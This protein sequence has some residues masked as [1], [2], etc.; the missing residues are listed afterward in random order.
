MK[1]HQL[2]YR[3][4]LIFIL[5]SVP[6]ML[7]GQTSDDILKSRYTSALERDLECNDSLYRV[8][9][10]TEFDYGVSLS[11]A[12]YSSMPVDSIAD[13][14]VLLEKHD[15]LSS[16][17]EEVISA[18]KAYKERL[19]VFKKAY[20]VSCTRFDSLEVAY[21][22]NA[23]DTLKTMSAEGVQTEEVEA[24]LSSLTVYS[25]QYSIV[26]DRFNITDV[27]VERR[28]KL[29]RSRPMD[30]VL[31]K[32]LSED[33]LEPWFISDQIKTL[34]TNSPIKY[35]RTVTGRMIGIL[36][37]M[38]SLDSSSPAG[39]A[40]ELLDELLSIGNEL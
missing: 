28:I 25:E 3:C 13:Y 11:T 19:C 29:Y 33:F 6:F 31:A 36:E 10:T 8:K 22:I 27:L 24:L 30:A 34:N 21:A 4:T 1:L 37:E 9:R 39:K 16:A 23:L 20:A 35:I 12:G 14:I 5:M 18:L 40:N 32:S 7:K 2:T 17:N 38:K 26:R 15:T